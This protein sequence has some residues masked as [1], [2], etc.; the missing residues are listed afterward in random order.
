M[1]TAVVKA[2]YFWVW[3]LYGFDAAGGDS[4]AKETSNK[5]CH[6]FVL[7]GTLVNDE[8]NVTSL[9]SEL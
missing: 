9:L 3:F 8:Q 7:H 1:L 6:S 2:E 4:L 5:S